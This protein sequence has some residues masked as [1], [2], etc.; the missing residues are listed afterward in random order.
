MKTFGFDTLFQNA[1]SYLYAKPDL[2]QTMVNYFRACRNCNIFMGTQN[3]TRGWDQRRMTGYRCYLSAG[4]D[5][6]VSFS[7]WSTQ[8]PWSCIHRSIDPWL[9]DMTADLYFQI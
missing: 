4:Y 5:E 8:I 9:E 3:K 1:V 2:L 7:S 6:I